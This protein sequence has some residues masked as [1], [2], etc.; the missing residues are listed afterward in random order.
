MALRYFLYEFSMAD[1]D[2]FEVKKYPIIQQLPILSVPKLLHYGNVLFA[3][4]RDQV[5][6]YQHVQWLIK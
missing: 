3:L 6:D 4:L 1:D 2:W 5:A